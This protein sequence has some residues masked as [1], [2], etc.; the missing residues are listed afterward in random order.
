MISIL[1]PIYNGIEF[2]DESV[3]TVLYQIFKEWEL[4]IGINGHP[5]NSSVFLTAKGY[6]KKD[7][8]IKVIDFYPIKGKSDTL[9]EMIKYAK[10]DWI[11][12]LDVD[13]KWLPKKLESQ[14][15]YM[16]NY[17]IIGTQCK[18]F[19]DYS[20]IPNIPVGDLKN[21]NFLNVNPI[22][23]S[24]CLIKKK[25]CYWDKTR[26]GVEDY[27]LWLKLWRQGKKFYN[28]SEIQVLHR[29]HN[30]S[31]FNAKGNNLKVSELKEKYI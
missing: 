26:D 14:L 24:S 3:P 1:M 7:S 22:I 27:D 17:D 5:I 21:H 16:K 29:I 12:L 18:Y 6:E 31:A 28:V 25:L 4:I 13:D 15:I 8:R 10:Y 11:S 30:D 2:I 19:E 9:N 20:I 23:N